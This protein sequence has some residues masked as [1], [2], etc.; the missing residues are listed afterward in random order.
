MNYESLKFYSRKTDIGV[1]QLLQ[2]MR[3]FRH[4]CISPTKNINKIL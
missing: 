4:K 2:V 3:F 1:G